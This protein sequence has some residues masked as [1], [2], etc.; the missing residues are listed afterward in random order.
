MSNL[1][2]TTNFVK[3]YFIKELG[4]DGLSNYDI[5]KA[6]NRPVKHINQKIERPEFQQCC[7]I[8]H[9]DLVTESNQIQKR[10][11]GRARRVILMQARAAKTL[12]CLAGWEE[13]YRYLDFLFDCEEVVS[14]EL[15]KLRQRIAELEAKPKKVKGKLRAGLAL[16]PM[17]TEDLLSPEFALAGAPHVYKPVEETTPFEREL[18]QYFRAKTLEKGWRM[19]RE[20]F[21]DKALTHLYRV[22]RLTH[23][24]ELVSSPKELH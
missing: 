9:Y 22:E 14:K 11:R 16:V 5:A 8:N 12:M 20:A 15:P 10:G 2:A 13:G 4:C 17:H 24:A 21:E 23:C 7:K 6:L 18:G 19:K 3:P 1:P